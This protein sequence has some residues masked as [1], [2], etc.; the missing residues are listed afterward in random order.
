MSEVPFD[1]CDYG[2]NI[3]GSIYLESVHNVHFLRLPALLRRVN[4]Q[5]GYAHKI[6][7]HLHQ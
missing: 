4:R 1:T 6:N 7:D 3:I 2:R 5:A